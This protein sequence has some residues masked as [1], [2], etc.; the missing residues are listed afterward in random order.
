MTRTHAAPAGPTDR[1][2]HP[3]LRSRAAAVRLDGESHRTLNRACPA[4]IAALVLIAL[5][6]WGAGS[7]RAL[8]PPPVPPAPPTE[9]AGARPAVRG[10]GPVTIRLLESRPLGA[11][12]LTVEPVVVCFLTGIAWESEVRKNSYKVRVFECSEPATEIE[13]ETCPQVENSGGTWTNLGCESYLYTNGQFTE[14]ELVE[15]K[16]C[17]PG[18]RYKAWY[19]A[20]VQPDE[21]VAGSG[22]GTTTTI[23]CDAG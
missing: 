7:A 8:A 14:G 1:V 23:G 2:W 15:L 18:R 13:V 21:A 10:T 20:W 9:G 3:I 12:P 19:W 17:T 4:A 5:S 6:G 11:H 16:S 22:S